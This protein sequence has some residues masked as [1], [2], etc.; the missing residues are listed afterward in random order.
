MWGFTK[1]SLEEPF[2]WSIG[3]KPS[4]GLDLWTLSL[5]IY[6]KF[7]HE[8]PQD[9]KIESFITKKGN[10]PQ[11]T[12]RTW[13][14]LVLH[15]LII[16]GKP[17]SSTF[18]KYLE[19]RV[20]KTLADQRDASNPFQYIKIGP[21]DISYSRRVCVERTVVQLSNLLLRTRYVSWI[22]K[23]WTTLFKIFQ[24]GLRLTTW[25]S[26]LLLTALTGHAETGRGEEAR[27]TGR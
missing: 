8:N 11:I 21:T 27:S 14:L 24:R 23:N 13:Q 5:I 2:A 1:R 16:T 19:F 18:T 26:I 9:F 20:N 3:E 22:P 12:S 4:K 10:K 25:P 17:L 15:K 6:S 7:S